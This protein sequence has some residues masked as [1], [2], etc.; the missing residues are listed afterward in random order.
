MILDVNDHTIDFKQFEKEVISI[1]KEDSENKS[2]IV[3]SDNEIK[4]FDNTIVS[5]G[6][7]SFNI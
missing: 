4:R 3:F 6:N 2:M 5:K 1:V 7:P